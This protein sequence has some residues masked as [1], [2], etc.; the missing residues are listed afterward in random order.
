MRVFAVALIGLAV[1]PLHSQEASSFTEF[2]QA[3]VVALCSAISSPG[4]SG[5]YQ[6]NVAVPQGVA[7]GDTVPV[8]LTVAGQTSS[9]ANTF[10][11]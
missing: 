1:I 6:V 8:T 10:V 2:R 11:Q 3:D 9:Q 4:F 5:L 7:P